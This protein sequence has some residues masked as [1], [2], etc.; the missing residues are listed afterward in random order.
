M[1]RKERLNALEVALNNEMREREFYLN[2]AK[3]TKNEVGRAMFQEIADEELEHYERLKQLHETWKKRE[4]W[5]E[6]VPLKVKGTVVKDVLV[7]M[8][9]K[10]EE[11]PEKDDDDLKAIRTAIDFEAKGAAYYAEIRD[12]VADPREKAFFDL[13]SK[14]EHEH[15]ASLKDTEE[16]LTNPASWYVKTEHHGLDGA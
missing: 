13:L 11:M 4:T 2:N 12:E 3:R 8:V 9:K 6:T 14:I 16:Y 15:Y 1:D 5:P 10:T 7:D